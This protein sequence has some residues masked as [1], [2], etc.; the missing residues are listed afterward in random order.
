MAKDSLES[1]HHHDVSQHE[2]ERNDK[3]IECTR[4]HGLFAV[5]LHLVYNWTIIRKN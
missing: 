5:L 1:I 2:L 4:I 3:T